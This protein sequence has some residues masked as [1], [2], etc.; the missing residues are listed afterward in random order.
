MVMSGMTIPQRAGPFGFQTPRDEIGMVIQR[1]DG[2]LDFEPQWFSHRDRPGDD[3]R[4]WFPQTRISL[5]AKA[6]GH[7]HLISAAPAASGLT[8]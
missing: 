4:L 6:L 2:S 1:A 3:V 8:R 7:S 5:R